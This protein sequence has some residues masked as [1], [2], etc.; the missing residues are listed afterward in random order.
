MNI[1]EHFDRII[2]YMY[3]DE[4]KHYE[5][6]EEKK[7]HIFVSIKAIKDWLESPS[8]PLVSEEEE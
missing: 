6:S 1:L 3:D 8:C 5:E 2:D 4:E 7:E